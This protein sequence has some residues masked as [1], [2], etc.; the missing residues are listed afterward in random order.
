M[1]DRSLL[2]EVR[3]EEV[4]GGGGVHQQL[5]H[6]PE[7]QLQAQSAFTTTNHQKQGCSEQ[8]TAGTASECNHQVYAS[9][10][11][12]LQRPP[13][14]LHAECKYRRD[15]MPLGL[16]G[17]STPASSMHASLLKHTPALAGTT[18]MCIL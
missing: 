14:R 1:E 8:A 6:A 9:I 17:I 16:T 3:A 11:W 7:Q 5:V 10:D 13:D 2:E 4:L 15:S 12:Q 18:T